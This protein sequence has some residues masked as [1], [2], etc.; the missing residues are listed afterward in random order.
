M[1]NIPGNIAKQFVTSLCLTIGFDKEIWACTFVPCA[2][3]FSPHTCT[4]ALR[5]SWCHS[6]LSP[7]LLLPWPFHH[8]AFSSL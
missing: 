3:F 8:I 6:L 1:K 7:S 5:L 2:L 4:R